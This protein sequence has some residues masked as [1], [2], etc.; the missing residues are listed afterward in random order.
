MIDCVFNLS[1]GAEEQRRQ[2]AGGRRQKEK[3]LRLKT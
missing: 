3:N 2:Q 1:K